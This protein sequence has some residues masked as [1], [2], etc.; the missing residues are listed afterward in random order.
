[1]TAAAP[2]CIEPL[3]AHPEALPVLQR[4]FE[5]EWPDYYGPGGVGDAAQDLRAFASA[6][7]SLPFGLVALRDGAPCGVAALKAESIVSHRHLTPWAAAGLVAPGQRRGG[8][9]ALLL[10]GLVE[11]AR[12]RGHDFLYC[13]TSTAGSLMERQGWEL[14]EHLMHDGQPLGVYRKAL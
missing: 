1:M 9:G 12:R 11:E 7:G 10:Q 3:S 2:V 14:L 6:G 13:G 8:I 4:W 5:Q